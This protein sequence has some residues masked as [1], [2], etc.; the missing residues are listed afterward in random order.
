MLKPG[1][2][3]IANGGYLV[4]QANDLLTNSLCYDTLKK[5]LRSK[6]YR[7]TSGS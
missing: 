6:K 4:F 7:W 5:V 1:L 3:H 2:L